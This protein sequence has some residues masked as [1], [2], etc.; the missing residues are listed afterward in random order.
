MPR[1]YLI[2][3]AETDLNALRTI[4]WPDTPLN[5]QGLWQATRMAHV[6]RDHR[7][8][9]IV[10]SDHRRARETAERLSETAGARVSTSVRLRERHFGALRGTAW[11]P[12]WDQFDSDDFAPPGGESGHAFHRRVDEAWS[13]LQ[14]RID[15]SERALAVVTHGLF[16]RALVRRHLDW[17]DR[18]EA[19]RFSNA[20]ITIVDGAPPW[21]VLQVPNDD[22]LKSEER[23]GEYACRSMR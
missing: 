4:Q 20:S 16:C 12:T 5:A 2:R 15:A 1:L 13:W 7:I 10:S 14:F 6:L 3:H 8:G 21:R 11:P 19:P 23:Q 22:H 18:P 9:D 17:P